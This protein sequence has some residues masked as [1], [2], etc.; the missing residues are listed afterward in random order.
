[1]INAGAIATT[2]MIWANDP[3]NAESV[4]M[5]FL[6]DMA[7]NKLTIDKIFFSKRK[8]QVTEIGQLATCYVI[9]MSSRPHLKKH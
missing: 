7:G 6:S 4:L 1:M 9:R 3:E 5:E 8:K 2:A